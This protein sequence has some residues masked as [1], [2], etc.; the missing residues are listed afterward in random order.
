MRQAQIIDQKIRSIAQREREA[1]AELLIELRELEVIRGYEELGFTSLFNYLTKGVGYSNGAAQRRI[2]ATRLSKDVPDLGE[3]LQSGELDLHHVTTVSKAVRQ[4]VKSRKVS[5]Q[6]KREIIESL[7]GQSEAETQHVVAQFFDL[8][9]ITETRRS[10]QKDESVRFEITVSREVAEMIERAQALVS[11]AV[12][13]KNLAEFLEYVSQKIIQQ[14]SQPPRERKQKVKSTA[15]TAVESVANA[16]MAVNPTSSVTTAAKS[17]STVV[18][19]VATAA[20]AIA[21]TAVTAAV[22]PAAFTEAI[23][24]SAQ[25]IP[26]HL[27]RKIRSEQPA[28]VRCGCSWFP[29]TDHRRARWLGGT[30]ARENLQTLCGPCNRAKYRRERRGKL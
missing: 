10:V 26:E 14:K 6:E 11:H 24:S 21:P 17:A 7:K 5:A 29:Q 9:V 18:E 19:P 16:M 13:S 27:H 8:E 15:T 1:L 25:R 30:N 3:R 2:D 20:L 22:E 23:D 4:A 12:P 28:C